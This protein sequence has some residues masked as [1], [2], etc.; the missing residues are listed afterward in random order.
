MV[1]YCIVQIRDWQTMTPWQSLTHHLVLQMRCY[2]HTLHLFARCVGL[3][4][5]QS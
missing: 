2:W 4:Q 1:Q 3:L 5:P